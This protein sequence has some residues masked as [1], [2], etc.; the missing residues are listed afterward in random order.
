MIKNHRRPFVMAKEPKQRVLITEEKS[1][2][3]SFP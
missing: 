1:C 3:D 2:Q